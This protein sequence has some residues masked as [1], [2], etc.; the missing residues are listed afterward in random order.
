MGGHLGAP[1]QWLQELSLPNPVGS[2]GSQAAQAAP[3]PRGR[4]HSQPVHKQ[5][6]PRHD[7]SP[8]YVGVSAGSTA[9]Q[10][11]LSKATHLHRGK[12]R[13]VR[14]HTSSRDL[15]RL[16]GTGMYVEGMGLPEKCHL[17][18][19]SLVP[20]ALLPLPPS[21]QGRAVK[22][23]AALLLFLF[24]F[25]FWILPKR[26]ARQSANRRRIPKR[27]G[28]SEG[29]VRE[30]IAKPERSGAPSR[31]HGRGTDASVPAVSHAAKRSGSTQPRA[32]KC[33]SQEL[34]EYFS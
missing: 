26:E 20:N 23:P 34:N 18:P 31:R 12:H 25:F 4:L 2:K 19:S 11:V 21:S 17:A 10:G 1:L 32:G 15:T 13:A 8:L 22:R 28:R 14:S 16:A 24:F 5:W 3:G 6:G 9:E 27:S 7:L 29:K 33:S 30:P